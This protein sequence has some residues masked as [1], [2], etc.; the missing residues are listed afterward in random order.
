MKINVNFRHLQM[1]NSTSMRKKEMLFLFLL[2]TILMTAQTYTL[3]KVLTFELGG[4]K[5]VL[6]TTQKVINTNNLDYSLE[7]MGD[8]GV[9]LL[10]NKTNFRH[11]FK[12][13]PSDVNTLTFN[14]VR[15]CDESKFSETVT[16]PYQDYKLRKISD[17]EY[18]LEKYESI[19][20]KNPFFE[21]RFKIIETE[22][23]QLGIL[24]ILDNELLQVFKNKM[25]LDKNY[26]ISEFNFYVNGNKAKRLQLAEVTPIDLEMSLPEKLNFICLNQ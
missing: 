18:A 5:K 19:D 1:Q 6:K 26:T 4:S 22:T 23:N 17:N 20:S 3:D 25:N 7:Y 16:R 24:H 8:R 12:Y 15:S 13:F 21:A 9:A 11:F 10:D 14:Y 2:V